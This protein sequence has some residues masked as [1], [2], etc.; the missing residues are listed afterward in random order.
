MKKV[1]DVLKES[2]LPLGETLI[3]LSKLLGVD[4]SILIA[5]PEI[6]IATNI[7]AVWQDNHDRRVFGEPLAYILGF[8]EFY[9]LK[10][11]VTPDVLIPRPE[12]EL[13][14]DKALAF[15]K[16]NSLSVKGSLS[17][18]EIGVG[19]GA[20]TLSIANEISRYGLLNKVEFVAT[21]ISQKA[22]DVAQ[23]NAKML[24]LDFVEFLQGN[25]FAPVLEKKF[26]LIIANLPYL[27]KEESLQNKYEPQLALDGGE[28][29]DE[30]IN[31]FL[32]EV[33]VFLRPNGLVLIE[34]YG[35]AIEEF[36]FDTIS[37]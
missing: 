36:S 35:G 26:D 31:K 14:V 25:L 18:L 37:K 20:I 22:L 34:K 9:G 17:V 3:L 19:S 16:T 24:G 7:D 10:F 13:I 27:P 8:K 29:G 12:S 2:K 30:L 28:V 1:E 15:I 33:E 5:H 11:L 6:A 32:A 23:K 4:K 21:D